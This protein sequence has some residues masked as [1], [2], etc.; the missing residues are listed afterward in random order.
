MWIDRD[1]LKISKNRLGRQ[2]AAL[3]C[4]FV[5]LF[6]IRFNLIIWNSYHKDKATS[7]IFVVARHTWKSFR[8]Y[9]CLEWMLVTLIRLMLRI[10]DNINDLLPNM[11]SCSLFCSFKEGNTMFISENLKTHEEGTSSE[12]YRKKSKKRKPVMTASWKWLYNS[13]GSRAV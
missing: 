1:H 13:G 12:F 9:S 8:C 3:S 2:N 4:S 5:F 7:G 6:Q 11:N 10:G